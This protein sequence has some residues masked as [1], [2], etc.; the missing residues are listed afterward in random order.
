MFAPGY[1][2]PDFKG[3]PY[4]RSCGCSTYGCI[5]WARCHTGQVI[6]AFAYENPSNEPAWALLRHHFYPDEYVELD[7]KGGSK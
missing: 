7:L 5:A 6:K 1:A 4:N 3:Y 2:A